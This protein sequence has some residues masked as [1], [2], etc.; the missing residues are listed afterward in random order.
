MMSVAHLEIKDALFDVAARR[1]QIILEILQQEEAK[2]YMRFGYI[3]RALDMLAAY[4]DFL[5]IVPP[6]R[7]K[8]LDRDEELPKVRNALHIIYLHLKGGL[9]NLAWILLYEFYPEYICQ[10]NRQYI[11]LFHNKYPYD[12]FCD[13]ETKDKI[14]GHKGW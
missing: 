4:H 2:K 13:D 3:A 11:D 7:T 5:N 10:K 1:S 8:P 14:L 9:D 6:E 12:K